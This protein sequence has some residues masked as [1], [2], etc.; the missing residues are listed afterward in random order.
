MSGSDI[1]IVMVGAF[2]I[3]CMGIWIIMS[4]IEDVTDMLLKI[5]RKMAEQSAKKPKDNL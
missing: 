5:Q 4:K 2:A 1:M 3:Q